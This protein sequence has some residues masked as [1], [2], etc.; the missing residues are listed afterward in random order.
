MSDSFVKI[1]YENLQ[2]PATMRI[3][4]IRVYQ[5]PET[6]NW[7]CDPKDFPTKEYIDTYIEAYKN[8]NLTTWEQ[9]GQSFPKNKFLGQC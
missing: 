9:Y 3:D 1:D 2:F 4:Y 5:D 7:G 6:H 8:P